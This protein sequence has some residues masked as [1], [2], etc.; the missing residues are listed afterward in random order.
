MAFHG[1]SSLLSQRRLPTLVNSLEWFNG[2]VDIFVDRALFVGG[3]IQHF[4]NARARNK[5]PS[6]KRTPLLKA[7][8][9]MQLTIFLQALR[10]AVRHVRPLLET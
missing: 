4:G 7:E 1:N 5:L 9:L 3:E 6:A 8:D 10:T 2:V